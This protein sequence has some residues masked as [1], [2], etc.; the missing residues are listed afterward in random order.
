MRFKKMGGGKPVNCGDRK[1]WTTC[2][3]GRERWK[4]CKWD[5]TS[6]K[7]KCVDNISAFHSAVR[8]S[9][10]DYSNPSKHPRLRRRNQQIPSSK[11]SLAH[12]EIMTNNSE[13]NLNQHTIKK[14]EQKFIDILEKRVTASRIFVPLIHDTFNTGIEDGYWRKFIPVL[15]TIFGAEVWDSFVNKLLTRRKNTT[16]D[17]T[18]TMISDRYGTRDYIQADDQTRVIGEEL[19]EDIVLAMGLI[20]QQLQ[21]KQST[22]VSEDV[23]EEAEAILPV[24]YHQSNKR[25]RSDCYR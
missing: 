3:V 25:K 24:N 12:R 23:E 22:I 1:K 10:Y 11:N 5:K 14:M 8:F 2:R 6:G 15:K 13:D 21:S 18:Y 4:K 9:A 17:T 20:V 16:I 7:G 19:M